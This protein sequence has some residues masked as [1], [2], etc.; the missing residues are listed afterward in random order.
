[1]LRS[2]NR[3][4]S[5]R[6]GRRGSLPLDLVPLATADTLPTTDAYAKQLA[7]HVIGMTDELAT[8][9]SEPISLSMTPLG[10]TPPPLDLRPEETQL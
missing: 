6:V 3:S 8:P 7:Q 5:K 10:N 2:R 9:G 4:K 1:M